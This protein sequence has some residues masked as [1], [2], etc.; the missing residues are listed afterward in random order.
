MARHHGQKQNDC[1]LKPEGW[2]PTNLGSNKTTTAATA[3]R[4]AGRPASQPG[5]GMSMNPYP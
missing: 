1:A 4:Q 3:G 5:L 2:P